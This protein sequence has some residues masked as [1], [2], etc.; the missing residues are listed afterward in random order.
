M[1]TELQTEDR[2]SSERDG[3]FK[4]IIVAVDLDNFTGLK[5]VEC[6]RA[7]ARVHQA[8][9][10]LLY[11]LPSYD[12]VFAYA[13]MDRFALETIS[14]D[15]FEKAKERLEKFRWSNNLQAKCVV[16]KGTPYREIINAAQELAADLL[17][18]GTHGY[19]GLKHMVLGSTAEQVVRYAPCPVLVL[20]P[21]KTKTELLKPVTEFATKIPAAR[22]TSA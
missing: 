4:E 7:M 5:A 9:I 12:M 10:T 6:A 17:I 8:N 2:T 22:L 13:E 20:R 14:Q 15:L 1:R 19:T 3:Y 11:V 21:G 16:K 18:V